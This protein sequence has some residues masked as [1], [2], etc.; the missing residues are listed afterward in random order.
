MVIGNLGSDAKVE[1]VNGREFV[2]FNVAH[3]ERWKTETGEIKESTQWVS[4]A[5][6]AGNKELL[7]HLKKGKSVFVIGH[8]SA[9][10]YSSPKTKRFEAGL[11]ISV[12]RLELLGGKPDIIPSRLY[13]ND[14]VEHNV[15]KAYYVSQEEAKALGVTRN[16]QAT[17]SAKDGRPFDV[18]SGGWVVEH[19][20][21][22]HTT[23]QAQ[24]AG[25]QGNEAK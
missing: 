5:M 25:Q 7:E 12:I 1:N 19:K 3:T 15:Y 14:G 8:G 2:S 24:A 16:K 11:N 6:D 10:C 17:L 21:Q 18:I 13:D 20:E 22:E 9:R 4:C 23:E